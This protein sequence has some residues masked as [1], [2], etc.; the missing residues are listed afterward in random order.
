MKIKNCPE[1]KVVCDLQFGSTGKGVIVGRIAQD[2]HPTAVA[3]GWGTNAGHTMITNFHGKRIATQVASAAVVGSV[4][5][6]YVGGGSLINPF[7]FSE[8]LDEVQAIRKDLGY[9]PVQIVIVDTAALILPQHEQAE[10]GLSSIGSTMKG[11]SA[12]MVQKLSRN[13]IGSNVIGMSRTLLHG[14]DDISITNMSNYVALMFEESRILLEGAQGFSLGLNQMFYPYCTSRECTPQQ[15]CTESG[16]PYSWVSEIIG[17]L[18]TY[19]IRVANRH[20]PVTNKQIGFSGHCYPDQK[21]TTFESIGEAVEKT[22]VTNLPR[23]IFTF[24]RDQIE[25]AI[26]QCSP[27]GLF[28]NFC[29][30]PANHKS[31]LQIIQSIE[32]TADGL[33]T[34]YPIKYLSYGPSSDEVYEVSTKQEVR[35]TISGIA[36]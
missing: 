5:T 11:N 23:R 31:L 14:R 30:Y 33:M 13:V 15:L 32:Y 21:E 28:L 2:W 18:R 19:P 6:V 36:Q 26:M 22:T 25:D 4:N 12:A 8:E 16:V 1:V 34:G 27:S 35:D 20:D 7:K 10:S 24:S 9:N 3:T 29:N 17:C